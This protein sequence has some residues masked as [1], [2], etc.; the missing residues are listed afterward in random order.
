MVPDR[1]RSMIKSFFLKEKSLWIAQSQ[2]LGLTVVKPPDTQVSSSPPTERWPLDRALETEGRGKGLERS[3]V[4]D[5]QSSEP[6]RAFQALSTVRWGGSSVSTETRSVQSHQEHPWQTS[7]WVKLVSQ[8][9]CHP[10]FQPC[11][12]PPICHTP[13]GSSEPYLWDP[14]NSKTSFPEDDLLTWRL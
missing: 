13:S 5:P 1:P 4:P 7:W 3:V 6:C 10:F 2:Q 8:P 9:T 11:P 14:I 12:P